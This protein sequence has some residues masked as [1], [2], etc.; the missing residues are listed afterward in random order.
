MV[1]YWAYFFAK[2]AVDAK[3][4]VDGRISEALFVLLEADALLWASLHTRCASAAV[5]LVGYLNH[6]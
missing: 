4:G 1:D 2:V 6:I 3:R 5:I